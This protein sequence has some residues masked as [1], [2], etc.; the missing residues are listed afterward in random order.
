MSCRTRY[1][2]SSQV[3]IDFSYIFE[4]EQTRLLN[5]S[6]RK[7]Q[8]PRIA[9]TKDSKR[10][11]VRL[12]KKKEALTAVRTGTVKASTLA[13]DASVR[14]TPKPGK[15]ERVQFQRSKQQYIDENRTI[16]APKQ[17]PLSWQKASPVGRKRERQQSHKH[18]T[19][20]RVAIRAPETEMPTSH[21]QQSGLRKLAL[22][23]LQNSQ[24]GSGNG[25]SKDVRRRLPSRN[26][27]TGA[28]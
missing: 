8:T 20:S 16:L 28:A 15:F 7:M 19:S 13:L 11:L 21:L 2:R 12:V 17:V 5:V 22:A 4:T 27:A 24:H 10:N 18:C 26:D 14:C 25:V 9:I 23:S 6:Y 3:L 1:P